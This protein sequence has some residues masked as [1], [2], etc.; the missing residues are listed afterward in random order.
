M[1]DPT[2]TISSM[3]PSRNTDVA[4]DPR[5]VECSKHGDQ[6]M[7]GDDLQDASSKAAT[8]SANSSVVSR[9]TS[10]VQPDLKFS[11]LTVS[12]NSTT[13]PNSRTTKTAKT[14]TSTY[15]A[16]KP[17]SGR[18]SVP[19]NRL[20]SSQKSSDTSGRLSAPL[21][22]STTPSSLASANSS[23]RSVP[24]SNTPE[25]A[26]SLYN[27]KR[28]LQAYPIFDKLAQAKDVTAMYYK[29]VMLL[30]GLGIH[31]SNREGLMGLKRTY[32]QSIRIP[33]D[34]EYRHLACYQ[35]GLAYSRGVGARQDLG[36]AVQWW[37]KA[38][39]EV[40]YDPSS[41]IAFDQQL[42][43]EAGTLCQMILARHYA[44]LRPNPDWEKCYNWYKEAAQ[45]GSV[46]S[47]YQTGILTWYGL[48]CPTDDPAKHHET[49]QNFLGRA[50]TAGNI[51]TLSQRLLPPCVP[52]E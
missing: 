10:A 25:S 2:P 46:E 30:D 8:S 11:K 1:N 5:P 34:P 48:G 17:M 49:I 50:A 35:I 12:T 44:S 23:V 42:N 33:C 16:L 40:R 47:M 51:C 31:E 6:E 26:K 27:Q 13:T 3:I 20:L 41:Q 29:A 37:L 43:T 19:V 28:F 22:R 39:N 45:N 14:V 32:D 4:Q 7:H 52:V 38:A 36:E 24:S 21:T 9:E 18:M 15:K